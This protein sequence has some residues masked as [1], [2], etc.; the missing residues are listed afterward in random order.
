M[1]RVKSAEVKVAYCPTE[2]R[3]ADF[4]TNPLQ[5]AELL[6]MREHILNKVSKVPRSVLE[7]A[8]KD[9]TKN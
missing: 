3:L 2:N 5:Q 1:D 4:L 9:V 7:K 8:K 6:K